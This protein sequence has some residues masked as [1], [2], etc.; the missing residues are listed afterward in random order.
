MVIREVKWT[1]GHSLPVLCLNASQN[2]P[3]AS[4]A[5]GG[6]VKV[7][8]KHGTLLGQAQFQ[9][10]KMLAT[11]CFLPSPTKLSTPHVENP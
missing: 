2:G 1:G 8:G 4:G 3:V 5:E 6:D 7:C 9:G 11:S 10:L